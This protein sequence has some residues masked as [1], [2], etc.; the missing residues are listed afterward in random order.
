VELEQVESV[1][2]GLGQSEFA[3]QEMNGPDAA[4]GDGFGLVG[5]L[6]VDVGGGDD[7]EATAL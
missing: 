2:D 7:R 4:A 1:V 5:D 3:D 6:V